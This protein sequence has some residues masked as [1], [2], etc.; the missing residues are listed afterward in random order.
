M[1]SLHDL[2][3]STVIGHSIVPAIYE[4][5][6]DGSSIDLIAGDGPA[7]AI[8]SVIATVAN[9]PIE[10]RLEESTDQSTWTDVAEGT[11]PDF[12]QGTDRVA[13]LRFTRTKRFVRARF[14]A[15]SSLSASLAVLIGQ[16]KKTV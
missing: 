6:E 7:F 3:S 16:Q 14:T 11:F 5:D 2:A 9:S 10:M 8:A 1:T 12:A 4:G 15:G 13:L